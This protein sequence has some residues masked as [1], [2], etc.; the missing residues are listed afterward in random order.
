MSRYEANP[1]NNLKSQPK[2]IPVDAYG[3][4][5]NPAPEVI[6]DRPNY[7]LINKIGNY[8][9]AYQS[10]S[11]STYVSGSQVT[12]AAGGP[13]RL[14]IN[15]VAWVSD[16]GVAGDVTFVYTGNVG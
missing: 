5:I 13:I 12:N 11:L 8:S 14:D 4:S 3:Q 9:F 1:N 2:A 16:G 7:I 10:G 15:P 6:T